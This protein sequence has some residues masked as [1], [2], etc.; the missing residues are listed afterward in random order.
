MSLG[1]YHTSSNIHGHSNN[2]LIG[3]VSLHKMLPNVDIYNK[4]KQ[5]K[6]NPRALK[7]AFVR[8]SC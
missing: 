3:F 4:R 1:I 2:I 6:K 8:R 5:N 7:M